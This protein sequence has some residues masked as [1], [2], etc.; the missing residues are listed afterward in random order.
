MKYSITVRL[1]ATCAILHD[2]EILDRLIYPYQRKDT[3]NISNKNDP[4]FEVKN[5][6]RV[7]E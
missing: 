7:M 4:H 6:K 2:L 1:Q 5:M 3:A